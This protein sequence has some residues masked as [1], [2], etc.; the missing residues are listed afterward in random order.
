MSPSG[1]STDLLLDLLFEELGE[2]VPVIG[3]DR[4]ESGESGDPGSSGDVGSPLSFRARFKA[5]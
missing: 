5:R 1:S 3:L 4:L 2:G